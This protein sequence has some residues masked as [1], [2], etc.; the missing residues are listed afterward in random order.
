[1][2]AREMKDSGIQ[3]IGEIPSDWKLNRIQYCLLEIKEKNLPIQTSQV[4]SLVKDKGVMLYEDKGNIGNKAKENITDYKLAYP[5][6]LIVNSMNILIGSVGISNYFGCVSP[7][8]YVFKETD[9]VELRFINYIFNTRELQTE[10]RKYAN[11]ILEIRLRVSADDIFKRKISLPSIYEQKKIANYLDIKCNETDSLVSDIQSQIDILEDYKKSIITE[12]VTKGLHLNVEMKDSG[13]GGIGKVPK[14]WK[15]TRFKYVGIIKSNLVNVNL[16]Q[17]YPQISPD[18]IAKDSGVLLGYN[19][20]AEAG[21]ISDNHLFYKGQILY[22]KIR[23]KLNK[24][25]IAPFDGLCSADMYP[26]ETQ[27]YTR[28]ILYMML[29]QYFL[30]Q[31]ALVTEDRVKMPKIN[32]EE[33]GEI[34]VVFPIRNIQKEIVKYLDQKCLEI[35][36]VIED[37]KKQLEVLEQYKKSF[38]YEYVTGKKEVPKNNV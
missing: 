31:V 16:Y 36:A 38:I 13:I 8:Y 33:L 12:A 21:V 10:L 4:L 19:T 37:K 11:G 32:K 26:I 35:D 2:M 5:N 20:V 24:V 28:F 9:N 14:D 15:I 1:M 34:K 30:N 18:N 17:E 3:W 23:P 27:E 6:T 7:V 29:S 22:S 25:T